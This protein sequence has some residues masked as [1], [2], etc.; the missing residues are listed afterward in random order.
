MA[1]N[2]TEEKNLP[3][4]AKRLRDLKKKGNV[5]H[6]RDVP[7]IARLVAV[8]LY[9][10][11]GGRYI[12]DQIRDVL[13][14]PQFYV[15]TDY[16]TQLIYALK[17]A[18]IAAA[19]AVFPLLL[20]SAVTA[21]LA[22]LLDL[23]GLHI[24]EKAGKI[25]FTKLNPVSGIKQI[26]TKRNLLDLIKAF[27]LLLLMVGAV[28]GIMRNYLNDL[29]WAPTCGMN[30]V[31]NAGSKVLLLIV[32]IGIALVVLMALIDIP[33]SRM[34]FTS[35]NKMS[36]SERKR[37]QKEEHGS[38]EVRKERRDRR[39]AMRETA[40]NV[41]IQKANLLLVSGNNAIGIRYIRGDTPAPI[42]VA[43]GHD[44]TVLDFRNTL[45][46]NKGIVHEAPED[47]ME[48]LLKK[49]PIGEYIPKAYFDQ[50][51]GI[52]IRTGIVG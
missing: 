6:S 4:T 37:E 9:L 28:W 15:H 1:G 19:Q 24:S 22:A 44:E 45:Y 23:R 11:I 31:I 21:V 40:G 3:P 35:E 47:L 18:G 26:F 14:L 43:K 52:L 13:T 50:V 30:C 38:P 20:F 49:A 39:N 17:L 16:N 48:A 51:A 7:T 2:D 42:V 8:V 32:C 12:G 33:I 5:P 34:L 36:T 41:G 29:L 46:L 10:V 25:D 27:I